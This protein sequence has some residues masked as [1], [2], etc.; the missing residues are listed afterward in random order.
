MHRSV[1]G[2]LSSPA[3]SHIEAQARDRDWVLAHFTFIACMT[4]LEAECDIALS[5]SMSVTSCRAMPKPDLAFIGNSVKLLTNYA[6]FLVDPG[7]EVGLLVNEAQRAIVMEAFA[8]SNVEPQWQMVFHGTPCDLDA[9]DT[10]KLT[11]HDLPAMQAL[12]DVAKVPLHHI[13]K[14]PFKQGPAFGIWDRRKLVAMGTTDIRAS[15]FVKIGNI[16][17]RGE[18]E[19]RQH[20]A[21]VTAVLVK[22]HAAP[23][24]DVFLIVPQQDQE[25]IGV[26]ER[27]GF[28]RERPMFQMH[29]L[30]TDME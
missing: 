8:V 24:T 14:N 16:V 2:R 21:H 15:G 1:G 11:A 23:N 28:M 19:S 9:G 29:C 12:A 17:A 3:A 26:F 7:S 13:A 25:A 20:V 4:T 27:L 5:P 10:T 6:S 30:L 18:L 22:A